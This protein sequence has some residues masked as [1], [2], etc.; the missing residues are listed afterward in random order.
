MPRAKK[1]MAGQPG[2]AVQA[3]TG[4]TY[5]DA[6]RQENLQRAMPAPKVQSSMSVQSQARPQMPQTQMPSQPS[7]S[8]EQTP[9]AR[10]RLDQQQVVERLQ[11]VSGI[12]TAPDDRPNLPVTDGLSTGPGRGPEALRTVPNRS[13]QIFRQLS[14]QTGDPIFAELAYKAGF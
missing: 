7:T 3:V 8:T 9:V 13:G 6:R 12:L 11:N 10:P 1:T 14:A 4:Q 2:Q 5:G